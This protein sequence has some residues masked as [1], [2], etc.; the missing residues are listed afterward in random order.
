[1]CCLSQFLSGSSMIKKNRSW[2]YSLCWLIGLI[3]VSS[4]IWAANCPSPNQMTQDR[5]IL[6]PT[7]SGCHSQADSRVHG[8]PCIHDNQ[9][10][11]LL[12]RKA[13]LPDPNAFVSFAP[14]FTVITT[15]YPTTSTCFAD[16][17]QPVFKHIFLRNSVFRI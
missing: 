8:I 3:L 17:I 1:M 7:G 5:L 14:Q 15:D 13:I 2:R 12:R 9:E 16:S 4:T 11:R 10:A 6:S